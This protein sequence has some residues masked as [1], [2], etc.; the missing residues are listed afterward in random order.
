MAQI[1]AMRERNRSRCVD[2]I[3]SSVTTQSLVKMM[4]PFPIEEQQP[5]ESAKL[6]MIRLDG[7]ETRQIVPRRFYQQQ[8]NEER[9]RLPLHEELQI[10]ERD[11][12]GTATGLF[13]FPTFFDF[14]DAFLLF[15]CFRGVPVTAADRSYTQR[16]GKKQNVTIRV[17]ATVVPLRHT[18]DDGQYG[19]PKS[20]TRRLFDLDSK[21]A[22]SNFVGVVDGFDKD[23]VDQQLETPNGT[24]RTGTIV[25]SIRKKCAT[26]ARV[27]IVPAQDLISLSRYGD[28]DAGEVAAIMKTY[29]PA[30]GALYHGVDL[31][32]RTQRS[33]N[34]FLKERNILVSH[35][36][37][38]DAEALARLALLGGAY[39]VYVLKAPSK[40]GISLL[41]RLNSSRVVVLEADA[42]ELHESVL[43]QSM[44]VI[45]DLGFLNNIDLLRTSLAPRGRLVCVEPKSRSGN[46]VSR[47]HEIAGQ[48]SLMKVKGTCIYDYDDMCKN[49]Y[50]D[51]VEDLEHLLELTQRRKLRP[52]VDK[53]I[54]AR[55]VEII[56]DAMRKHPP[57]GAIICE[58]WREHPSKQ[59]SVTQFHEEWR[60][61][62]SWV[63]HAIVEDEFDNESPPLCL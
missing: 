50:G 49:N 15:S 57:R 56:Q 61:K 39:R 60:L 46:L 37:D 17:E 53:Y 30:F 4:H 24:V 5:R 23:D 12:D 29:L 45:I 3:T 43:F 14:M 59:E 6:A 47:L 9:E 34:G 40:T 25:T 33:S 13:S 31:R 2:I 19:P 8:E 7:L 26:K 41:D 38:I 54:K 36:S 28:L 42:E 51:V 10:E 1:V 18:Q 16:L 11:N 32:W 52:L 22:E 55:D 63:K 20:A 44:D 27:A 48:A 35:G 21:L 58:P 62:S